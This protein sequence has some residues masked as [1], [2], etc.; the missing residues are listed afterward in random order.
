L[1]PSAASPAFCA[2]H[3]CQNDAGEVPRLSRAS[4]PAPPRLAPPAV[5]T[6]G[7]GANISGGSGG[8]LTWG[9][10]GWCRRACTAKKGDAIPPRHCSLD[11]RRHVEVECAPCRGSCGKIRSAPWPWTLPVPPRLHRQE[12]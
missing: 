6:A 7:N 5:G 11:Q 9:S 1:S 8:T 4:S 2:V 12:G 3:S 10:P